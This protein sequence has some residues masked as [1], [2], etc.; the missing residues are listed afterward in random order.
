MDKYSAISLPL[1]KSENLN[2]KIGIDININDNS[3]QYPDNLLKLKT[4]E[5]CQF[6]GKSIGLSKANDHFTSL[7]FWQIPYQ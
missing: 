1:Q 4:S 6:K 7:L 5:F 3:Y 2:P